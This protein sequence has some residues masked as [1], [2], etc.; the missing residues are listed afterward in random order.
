MKIEAGQAGSIGGL[1]NKPTT[2]PQKP[3]ESVQT[4]SPSTVLNLSD[5][6][7]QIHEKVKNLDSYEDVREDVVAEAK[8]DLQ[9]WDS[10]PKD[11]IADQIFDKMFEEMAL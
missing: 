8:A 6:T 2:A 4:D 9:K 5:A 3:A 11:Q 1:N 7:R 10:L